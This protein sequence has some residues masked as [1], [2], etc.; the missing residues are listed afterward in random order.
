M[1]LLSWIFY[2]GSF[3]KSGPKLETL[4]NRL[5][6]FGKKNTDQEMAVGS[7][8]AVQIRTETVGDVTGSSGQISPDGEEDDDKDTETSFWENYMTWLSFI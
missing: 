7:L 1:N 5:E 2:F 6:E 8:A 3:R 4:C